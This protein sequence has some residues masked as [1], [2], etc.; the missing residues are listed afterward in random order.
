MA[1]Q[2]CPKCKKDSFTW[3][4]DDDDPDLTVWGCY[5]CYYSAHENERDNSEC[6]TCGQQTESK[7]KDEQNGDWRCWTCLYKK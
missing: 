2:L 1:T 4:M 7:F 6:E 5:E 3:Q